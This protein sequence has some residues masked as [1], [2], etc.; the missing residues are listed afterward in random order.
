[1]HSSVASSCDLDLSFILTSSPILIIH[2]K[3]SKRLHSSCGGPCRIWCPYEVK[4]TQPVSVTA[5]ERKMV[6]RDSSLVDSTTGTYVLWSGTSGNK[7]SYSM[8][9]SLL[10]NLV[11]LLPSLSFSCLWLFWVGFQSN[12]QLI[13]QLKARKTPLPHSNFLIYSF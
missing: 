8:C 9:W 7:S 5:W 13:E 11:L 2:V 12:Q 3:R 6:E 10:C 1:V 4:E